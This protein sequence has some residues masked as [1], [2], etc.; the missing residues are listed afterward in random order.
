LPPVRAEL[1]LPLV[2]RCSLI[3]LTRDP[4]LTW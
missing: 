1:R 2:L 4:D 3:S